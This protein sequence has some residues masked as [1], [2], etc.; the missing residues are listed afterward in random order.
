MEL[1]IS[2]V[3]LRKLLRLAGK[4]PMLAPPAFYYFYQLFQNNLDLLFLIRATSLQV[5]GS[6]VSRATFG[7]VPL[8][9]FSDLPSLLGYR[10]QC[11]QQVSVIY[12]GNGCL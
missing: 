5:S 11:R 8:W 9:A 2:F 1:C 7:L 3:D 10:A 4:L 12:F 6:R